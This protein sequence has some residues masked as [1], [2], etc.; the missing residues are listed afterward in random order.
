MRAC[1]IMTACVRDY[2]CVR[3]YVRECVHVWVRDYDCVRA[4]VRACVTAYVRMNL[5]IDQQNVKYCRAKP[6]QAES[7]Q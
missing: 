7:M 6:E 3:V 5:C 2:D 1:V 4:C